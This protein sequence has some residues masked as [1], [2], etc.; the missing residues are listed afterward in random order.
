[1]EAV[2]LPLLLGIYCPCLTA[3]QECTDDARFVHYY[4]G[5]HSQF[6]ILP[7]TS[8]QWAQHCCGLPATL[9]YFGIQGKL[10]PRLSLMVEPR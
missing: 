5:C 6:G 1:M 9:V 4:I 7:K 8:C 10:S 3:V 2:Q